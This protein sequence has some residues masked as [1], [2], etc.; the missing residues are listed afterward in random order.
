MPKTLKSPK[1]KSLRR[2]RAQI[3][4]ILRDAFRR[5]FP[6]DT[7]DISNGYKGNIHVLVVSRQFDRMNEREKPS[8]MWH[9]IDKTTLSE[10]EKS[11]ISLV[12][13]LSPRELK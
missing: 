12:L 8:F 5:A 6:N 13:P 2:S 7:V 11:L 10:D 3:K 9:L 4:S 1:A